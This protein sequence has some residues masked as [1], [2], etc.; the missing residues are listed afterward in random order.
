MPEV[1]R[2]TTTTIQVSSSVTVGE[3]Q[4]VLEGLPA[5]ATVR[6]QTHDGNQRE[7]GYTTITVTHR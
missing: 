5:S 7:P 1:R 3:L 4:S 2:T 6:F